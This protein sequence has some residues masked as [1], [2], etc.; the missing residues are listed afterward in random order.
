MSRTPG[1]TRQINFFALD[2]QRYLVDLPGY[3]FAKVSRAEKQQWARLVEQYLST[4]QALAGLV[5]LMDVRRPFTVLDEQL[6]DW[7]LAAGVDFHLALTKSDKLPRAGGRAALDAARDRIER[8]GA[9]T[10]Q[11]F[12]ATTR[13]GLDELQT[14]VCG[15]LAQPPA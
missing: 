10:V 12:S 9:G 5:V 7:A 2:L 11:L 14:R 13:A 4:R 1:R 15:W 3:G 8:H 6:V